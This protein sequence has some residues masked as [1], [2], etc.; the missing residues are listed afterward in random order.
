MI[1]ILFDERP[2]E[3]ARYICTKFYEFFVHPDPN[4]PNSN[5]TDIINGLAN[6]MVTNNFEIAPV[7]TEL[8]SSQH[9]FD[10]ASIGVII[11]S[12][13]DLF[14]GFLKDTNFP[15][16][17][18]ITEYI[19]ES[20]RRTGQE[21]FS[22]VDVAGWQRDR[23]WINSYFMIGRWLNL[24]A[25]VDQLFMENEDAFR[26]LAMDLVG[27]ADSNTS[28]PETVVTAFVNKFTPKGLLTNQDYPNALDAFKIDD[29]PED[30]YAP[31]HFPGGLSLWVL[32]ISP[33]VPMQVMVLLK[34]L[35]REPEFQLK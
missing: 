27:A 20:C 7:L 4:D 3:I 17:A 22:P 35:I 19:V 30:Y 16:T 32:S 9:F 26:T 15:L 1:N 2:N 11:K 10:E 8:F 12:P 14:L 29:I 33:E 25:L 34:H 13:F 28:N 31:E 23:S 24:E 18:P 21:L 6:T 5:A